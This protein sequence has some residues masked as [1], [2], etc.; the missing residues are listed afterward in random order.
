MD[1]EKIYIDT[2]QIPLDEQEKYAGMDVAIVDGKVVVAGRN[3]IEALRKAQELFPY[4][5][6][7]DADFLVL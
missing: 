3:S 6:K 4:I 5:P 2:P 7:P 1:G